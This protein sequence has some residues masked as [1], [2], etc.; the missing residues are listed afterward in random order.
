MLVN[1]EAIKEVARSS[2]I[3]DATASSHWDGKEAKGRKYKLAEDPFNF[4]NAFDNFSVIG[5][6]G[7]ISAKTSFPFKLIHW[8]LQIPFRLMGRKLNGF[9]KID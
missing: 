3:L 1:D 8:L 4:A 2:S 6:V 7:A 9:R 5:P